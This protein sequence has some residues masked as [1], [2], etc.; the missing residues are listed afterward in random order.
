MNRVAWVQLPQLLEEGLVGTADR[1]ELG[2]GI[3]E[4]RVGDIHEFGEILDAFGDPAVLLIITARRGNAR[5]DRP[6]A[7]PPAAVSGS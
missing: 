5:A 2:A 3:G 6:P 7:Q 1:L 4:H